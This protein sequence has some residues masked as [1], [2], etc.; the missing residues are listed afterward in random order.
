MEELARFYIFPWTEI[1]RYKETVKNENAKNLIETVKFKV[2]SYIDLPKEVLKV[3]N[4]YYIVYS[5]NSY[6]YKMRRED[7]HLAN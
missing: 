6:S 3:P 1:F 2:L 4:K 5:N 7:L